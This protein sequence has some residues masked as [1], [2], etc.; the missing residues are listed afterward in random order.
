MALGVDVDE[1]FNESIHLPMM[2]LMKYARKELFHLHQKKD[3]YP[4]NESKES[5]SQTK[6]K[7]NEG[8]AQKLE[9]QILDS[10]LKNYE[11]F[12]KMKLCLFDPYERHSEEGISI[13]L[14]SQLSER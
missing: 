8:E 5:R 11:F 13:S 7:T 6:R 14:N 9:V 12:K 10:F 3:T 1:S 4:C 2:L